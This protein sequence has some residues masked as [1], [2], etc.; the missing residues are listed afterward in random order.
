MRRVA[1]GRRAGGDRRRHAG[2]RQARSASSACSWSSAVPRPRHIEVQV[3]ADATGETV[4]LFERDCSVQ[5]RHQKVV[6]IAP[7]PNLDPRS[8]DGSAPTPSRSRRRIGYVNAGT[9]EFLLDT[10]G[11]R[12]GARLHRDE[13]ADP[14]RAHGD[15]GGHRR[16]PGAVQLRIASGETLPTSA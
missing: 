14:G 13:P 3:L 4:H 5:R 7:A 15:R 2:G 6:E 12:P 9:V 8:G 11:E 16:R 1:T 10:A